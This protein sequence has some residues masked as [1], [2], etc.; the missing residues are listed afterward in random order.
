MLKK[1]WHP[2]IVSED[3]EDCQE[4]VQEI[5]KIRPIYWLV[6]LPAERYIVGVKLH[7]YEKVD[8]KE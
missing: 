8:K 4:G 2:A 3:Y 7:A 5:V 1:D 6:R